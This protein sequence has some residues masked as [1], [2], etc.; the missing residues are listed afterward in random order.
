LRALHHHPLH[1]RGVPPALR[2]ITRHALLTY[3]ARHWPGWQFTLLCAI[4]RGEAWARRFWARWRGDDRAAAM[5][6]QL[7]KLAR[8]LRTGEVQRV[9]RRLRRIVNLGDP[10]CP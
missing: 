1:E 2:L 10:R 7:G 9:Q 4:V 8:D 5:F 6:K 3:A